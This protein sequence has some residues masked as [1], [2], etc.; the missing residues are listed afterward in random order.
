MTTASR[1]KAGGN[2]AWPE[3]RAKMFVDTLE[4]KGI[5]KLKAIIC[6]TERKEKERAKL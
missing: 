5:D 1:K 4:T 3:W 6:P 2:L